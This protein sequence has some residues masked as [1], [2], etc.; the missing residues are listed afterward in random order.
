M[1]RPSVRLE[2]VHVCACMRGD[3]HCPVC[4]SPCF[5]GTRVNSSEHYEESGS[6]GDLTRPLRA[7]V[8]LAPREVVFTHARGNID[9]CCISHF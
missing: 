1:S 5:N 8:P 9:T 4:C 6:E 3:H 2:R 7:A